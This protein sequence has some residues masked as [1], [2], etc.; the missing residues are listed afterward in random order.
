M[1]KSNNDTAEVLVSKF[2][3]VKNGLDEAEVLSTIKELVERNRSLTD[4]FAHLDSLTK[5]AERTVIQAEQ[6][7]ETIKKDAETAATSEAA[8]I[9]ASAEEK[10]KSEADRLNAKPRRLKERQK[11]KPSNR[12]QR[13]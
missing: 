12:L 10:A 7:A 5:L 2:K 8:I 6:E 1:V 11:L 9:V 3:K 4:R 13:L